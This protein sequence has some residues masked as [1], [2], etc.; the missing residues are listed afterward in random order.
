MLY[1]SFLNPSINE[2]KS[3][4][5]TFVICTH[6]AMAQSNTLWQKQSIN[7]NLRLKSSKQNLPRTQTFNLNAEGLKQA[8]TKAPDRSKTS[9]ESTVVLSFPN[10][11]GVFERFRIYEASIMEPELAARYPEIKSYAGQGIDDP[12]AVIRFSV[13]HLGF[14]SMRLSGNQPAT[15]IETLNNDT[16]LYTAYSREQRINVN[17]D[18]ECSV[19]ESVNEVLNSQNIA[20]RNADDGVLRTYRLAVSATGE[21]T[22]FHGGTVADA[23]AAIN[24]TMVRVNGIFEV[25]FSVRL[26]LIGNTDDVIYTNAGTDPYS[27][28]GAYNGQLQNTLTNVIGEANY[29]IGHLFANLQNNGNAGCIGCVCVNGQKGRGW[30]SATNPTG[31]FFDVDYVAHEMGHQFGANHTWTHGGNEGTGV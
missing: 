6:F 17:N 3:I 5:I 24:Q 11:E 29:D 12:T 8:L 31:D 16:S 10:S 27:T 21:Y 13:S 18:F 14:Q 1:I 23:L 20:F 28:T 25:D 7:S 30:T 4:I 22:N 15:F 2:I 19:T 9:K 26:L